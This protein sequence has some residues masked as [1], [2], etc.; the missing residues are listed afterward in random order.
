MSL[1]QQVMTEMKDAMKAKDEGT[2]RAL[3]SNKSRDH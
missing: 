3:A 2:L 1:E